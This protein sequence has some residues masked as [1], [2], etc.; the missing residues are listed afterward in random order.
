MSKREYHL[1]RTVPVELGWIWVFGSNLAGRH[2]AGAAEVARL[3][4]GAEYGVG[5]GPTGRAYGIPTKSGNLKVLS[6]QQIQKS[7]EEFLSYARSHPEMRFF[8]TRIGCELAGFKDAQIGPLFAKAPLNCS[9]PKEWKAY[10]ASRSAQRISPSVRHADAP[11][12]AG[13]GSRKTPPE[14]LDYMRRFARRMAVNG[15]VLRSGA[16]DGADMAFELGCLEAGGQHEI[17]LPWK[18]F[19]RHADSG[20]YPGD[21]HF[22]Q[23]ALHHPAWDNLKHS[24]R[25]LH[26][27][28]VGQVLG[29]DIQTP[30]SLV[31]CWTPDGCENQFERTK[32]TGGTGM[33][34]AV[35]TRRE[36]P[37]PVF[38][39]AREGSKERLNQY[40]LSILQHEERR[41]EAPRMTQS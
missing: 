35:A 33:A 1:D 24:V 4:F 41:I 29:A 3:Q 12:Y 20:F 9:L 17:W 23:A 37:I 39:L 19:N 6:Y 21:V 2:G 25:S 10:E 27:R 38:N 32:E 5:H 40:V 30:A 22:A 13:I 26:A 7:V 11:Y 36:L 18:G 16:A 31:V 15:F 28:N 34:I 14:V 8:V